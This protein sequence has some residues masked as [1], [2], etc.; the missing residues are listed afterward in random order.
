M[1]YPK[2]WAAIDAAIEKSHALKDYSTISRLV[3]YMRLYPHDTEI[4]DW[5]LVCCAGN[6]MAD[7]PKAPIWNAVIDIWHEE[8]NAERRDDWN[9]TNKVARRTKSDKEVV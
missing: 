4:L 6:E 5:N 9:K 7:D 8:R 1:K 2:T 3:A